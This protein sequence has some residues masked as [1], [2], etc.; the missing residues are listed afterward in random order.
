M[1]V[2]TLVKLG[3]TASVGTSAQGPRCLGNSGQ[4]SASDFQI[5][6]LVFTGYPM[7]KTVFF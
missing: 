2:Q 4:F 5:R 6:A 1:I 3:L 7:P